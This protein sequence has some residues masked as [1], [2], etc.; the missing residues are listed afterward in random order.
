LHLCYNNRLFCN[1]LKENI[2][3]RALFSEEIN[4]GRYTIGNSVTA[5]LTLLDFPWV[6]V[7]RTTSECTK[8]KMS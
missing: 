5:T 3:I 7:S 6:P 8:S 2:G 1:I 4:I